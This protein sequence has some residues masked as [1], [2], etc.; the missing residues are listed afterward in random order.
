M[1]I[2]N[3]EITTFSLLVSNMPKINSTDA[4]TLVRSY[5][6]ALAIGGVAKYIDIYIILY[7]NY[8]YYII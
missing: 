7:N 8:N 5:T 6:V 1:N 2:L 3:D 4:V